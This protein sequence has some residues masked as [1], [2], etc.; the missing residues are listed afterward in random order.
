VRAPSRAYLLWALGGRYTHNK[1]FTVSIRDR[2]AQMVFHS[3]ATSLPI[4]VEDLD[5]TIR[6]YGGFGSTGNKLSH[7]TPTNPYTPNVQ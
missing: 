4:L 5:S 6:G 2:I 3:I 7:A 1:P